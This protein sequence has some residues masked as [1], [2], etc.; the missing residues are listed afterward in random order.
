MSSLLGEKDV[1]KS[2]FIK[3]S[4]LVW[5]T[6]TIWTQKGPTARQMNS[7]KNRPKTTQNMILS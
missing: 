3:L 4:A 6:I 2:Y 5:I 1:S 7:W